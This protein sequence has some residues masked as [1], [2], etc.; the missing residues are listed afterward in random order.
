MT[1]LICF[2]ANF[3]NV[4]LTSLEQ[5]WF[6]GTQFFR[7]RNSDIF[8]EIKVAKTQIYGSFEKVGIKSLRGGKL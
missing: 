3:L 6:H 5:G 4:K 1:H 8:N 7:L 2:S